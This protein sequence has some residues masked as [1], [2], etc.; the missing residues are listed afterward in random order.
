MWTELGNS[1]YENNSKIKTYDQDN[2]THFRAMLH[3]NAL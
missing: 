2:L 3:S 1:L